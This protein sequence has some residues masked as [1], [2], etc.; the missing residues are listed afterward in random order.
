MQVCS[1]VIFINDG[2]VVHT[3]LITAAD[4]EG[5]G[6]QFTVTTMLPESGKLSEIPAL[7]T[8]VID[9][10]KVIDYTGHIL[11][12]CFCLISPYFLCG[13][14]FFRSQNWTNSFRSAQCGDTCLC[15]H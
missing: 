10:T 12:Q 11:M 2:Y 4:C 15:P 3:P 13:T 5:A 7:K 1:L 9:Y 8:G 14:G 6:E